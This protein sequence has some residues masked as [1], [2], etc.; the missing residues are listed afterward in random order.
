MENHELEQT[1]YKSKAYIIIYGLLLSSSGLYFGYLIGN[2]NTFGNI[3]LQRIYKED[4][5]NV[6]K[7]ILGNINLFFLLGGLLSALTASFIYEALGRYKAL[8]LLSVAKIGL[9]CLFL[10]QSL[11]ALYVG[12][13]LGGYIGCFSTFIAPLMMKENLPLRYAGTISACFYIF[14]TGGILISYGFGTPGAADNWRLVFGGPLLY[15]VPVFLLYLFVFK[16]ESPKSIYSKSI[17]LKNDL[18]ENYLYMYTEQ[19][20]KE[21]ASNFVE[22]MNQMASTS[23]EVGFRDLFGKQYRLQFLL[24]FFLNLLNQLTG[25]NFLVLYSKTIFESLDIKNADTITFYMGFMNFLGAI[26]VTIFGSSMGKRTSLVAGLALQS[27]SYFALLLGMVFK[28]GI[29][30]IIGAYAYIFSFA[31]SIGGMLYVYLA[32]I[33]PPIGISLASLSQWALACFVGKYALDVMQLFGQFNVFYFFMIVS[34]AG[35]VIFAGY[36]V[37]TQGK[38][39]VQINQEFMNKKF[40]Q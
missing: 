31:I 39:E 29:L 34:F 20:A 10:I 12:R 16:M 21:E 6:R 3:F 18:Y 24:G 32:D 9:M 40:L 38:T 17:D 7:E 14:L 28:I 36:S 15:E 11:N 37:E 35:C 2:F 13:F 23:S 33:V 22:E 30:V 8:L 25:I 4:N 1:P 26:V 27:A 19:A 5:E